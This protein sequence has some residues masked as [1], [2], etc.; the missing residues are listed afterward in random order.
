VNVKFDVTPGAVGDGVED[1]TA[2]IQ[3]AFSRVKEGATIYLPAGTYRITETLQI[4]GPL[5][6]ILIVGHGRDTRLVWDGRPGAKMFWDDGAA[7]SRYVGLTLDGR[8][9]AAVGL[10]HN[11]ST[12]FETEVRHQHMAF[13]NLSD[14]GILCDSQQA[15][16]ETMTENCLFENCKRGIA[17][18]RWNDYDFTID[19]CEFRKCGTAIEC[20]HGNTYVRNCHFEANVVDIRL[21]NPEH[22][23]TV[24]R[25]TSVGSEAFLFAAS[26]VAP[27]TVEGCQVSSWTKAEATVMVRGAPAMIFDCVFT[28]PPSTNPPVKLMNPGQRIF[29]SQNVSAQTDGIVAPGDNGKVFT[30]PA[31]KRRGALTSPRQRFLKETVAIPAF[32]FDARRDF[33]AKADGRTDDTAAIQRTI[34]AARARGKG[35]LA[36]LPTGTYRITA[37]LKVTGADYY[38]GGSGFRSGLLWKGAAGGTIMEVQD[39][40]HVTIEHIAIGNHDTAMNMTNTH[41]ILQTSSAENKPSSVTYDNVTVYGLYQKKP[42]VKGLWLRGLSPGSVVSMPH[43]DGNIHLVDAARATVLMSCTFEGSIVIEGKDARRDGFVGALTHLGTICTHALYIKDNHSFVASDFYVEQADDGYWFEGGAGDP[44]GRITIQ[45]PKVDMSPVKDKENITFDINNYGGAI[46]FGPAQ[47]Y[48]QPL[49][50]VLRHSGRRPLDFLVSASCFY[51]SKLIPRA[52]GDTLKVRLLG[53]EAVEGALPATLV[54]DNP[55]SEQLQKMAVALDD[56]RRLGELDLRVNHPAA[57]TGQT[58][59]N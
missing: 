33:G 40:Q 1:D 22:A 17:F 56:L 38:V 24:R 43:I 8:N 46:F 9:K 19:G 58:A 35:A 3:Q 29:V 50:M 21:A 44:D 18:V 32:V 26:P 7:N 6:G 57:L 10:W 12:R 48:V 28:D 49:A 37:P 14:A 47:F 11:N 20:Q 4:K 23:S 51:R 30:I 2:A 39:P 25:C 31:G 55:S 53:C 45:A 16:A 27:F 41:D 36:Y 15:T 34:D 5:L 52:D 59:G 13:L 54:D 42:F